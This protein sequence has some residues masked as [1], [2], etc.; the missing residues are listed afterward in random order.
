ML[1]A[2]AESVA[3]VVDIEFDV[4]AAAAAGAAGTG[5]TADAGVDVRAGVIEDRER[6]PHHSHYLR[7]AVVVSCAVG[8]ALESTSLLRLLLR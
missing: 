1:F 6:A 5:D 3:V 2:D 4:D 7:R 8:V